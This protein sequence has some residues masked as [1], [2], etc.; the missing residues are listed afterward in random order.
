MKAF[1][2]IVFSIG[3]LLCMPL[4]A[5]SGLLPELTGD[6]AKIQSHDLTSSPETVNDMVARLSDKEVRSLLLDYLLS[7]SDT[8]VTN[9]DQNILQFLSSSFAGISR[10]VQTAVNRLPTLSEK[11]LLSF[12][13]FS[14][15][16]SPTGYMQ[17]F[18]L[19]LLAILLAVAAEKLTT[20]AARSWRQQINN[21]ETPET[22]GQNL[23]LLLMRFTLDISGLVVFFIVASIL[24]EQFFDGIKLQGAE[25]ILV[26]LVTLPRATGAISRFLIAPHRP[27]LR[28]IHTDDHS[29][30][31]L[32]RHQ[33]QLIALLGF[34][35]GIVA[36]NE[37]NGIPMGDTRLGFWLNLSIHL[38]FIYVVWMTRDG[39]SQMLIGRDQDVTPGELRIAR[40]YPGSLIAL[41]VIMWIVVEMIVAN[42][43]FDIIEGFIHLWTILILS[44]APVFDTAIRGMVR[45]LVKPM[46]G[47]GLVA[48]RAYEST[49]RSYIRIGRLIA[50]AI[51]VVIISDMWNIDFDNLAGAGLGVQA[52]ALFIEFLIIIA[53]GYLL[54]EIIT[55]W[56]N[57]K[58][59][60][61]QTAA[62]IDLQEE[63]I[64]GEGGGAGSSRLSTILPLIRIT[65]QVI[66]FIMT[67]LI[68]LSH[69]GINITPL[70]AGAGIA[71][72]AI[73]FGAQKLVTD[74]VS[75]IFFL[76]DDAFRAG[77][78][79][80]VEGTVGTV[81]KI[82]LRSMQLRHH[83]GHVHTIPYGQIPK[84]TNYSRDWVIMKLRFTVPFDTDLTKVKKIFKQIGAEM[85]EFPE[86]A[87]D[88]IQ[89]FKSQGV[90]EVDDVGIVV[91]GKFM[92]K[93]GKQFM[94]RKEIYQRVQKAFD[95]NGLQFARKEVRVR[96]DE[97]PSREL[98]ED[99][100]KT[101]AGAASD[102]IVEKPAA[103]GKQK[104]DPI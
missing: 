73:G 5:Q 78:Y 93:P 55:L 23:K 40:W 6:E 76:I 45:H 75:G 26:Y 20:A 52:A 84:I 61:E 24:L 62:G 64:G 15:S 53:G 34:T 65:S 21:H 47:E 14:A 38:Y 30:K 74:I 97:A 32:Y 1:K 81:E 86:F 96:L 59:A 60:D 99:E 92:A 8:D 49:K 17:F 46:E 85:M 25:I 95:E 39:L 90:L 101:I 9:E 66:I 104:S 58:L 57:R 19:F 63:E 82:S 16:E 50:F 42:G 12:S 31:Y 87:D 98:T 4:F 91:R 79:V 100:K 94:L 28:L 13:N 36:F 67:V 68:A 27:E 29:A 11:Q 54:G 33:I 22:L 43:R 51:V 80:D 70:L 71:G 35:V 103:D 88:F 7:K 3:V 18:G 69:V 89:P 41:S 56:I 77:E 102:A 2:T 10:Q 44:Y 72:I 83:R 37:I 48:E